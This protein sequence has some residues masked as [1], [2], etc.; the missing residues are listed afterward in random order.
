MRSEEE[1]LEMFHRFDEHTGR[2]L[3]KSKGDNFKYGMWVGKMIALEWAL[4]DEHGD[5]VIAYDFEDW[6]REH[7]H[8]I[9]ELKHRLAEDAQHDDEGEE[10]ENQ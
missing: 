8:R 4:G 2:E 7:G 3:M 6:E 1:V 9:D 10:D 5:M